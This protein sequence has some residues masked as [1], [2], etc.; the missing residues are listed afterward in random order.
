MST[1]TLIGKVSA[2]PKGVWSGENEY[3]ILD[4]VTHEG[5]GYISLQDVPAGTQITN[6]SYWLKFCEKGEKGDGGEIISASASIDS[7]YGTPTVSVFLGG[8]AHER[9]IGFEFSHLRGNGIVSV[10]KTST[11][12]SVDTYTITYNNG[13]TSTFTVTNGSVTSV[14][15]ETG[16]V[17]GVAETDGHYPELTS[18]SAEQLL[19]TQCLNDKVP[20]LYR[21]SGG[22]VNTGDRKS[23]SIVGGSIIWNQLVD[24]DTASVT[25]ADGHKYY[26]AINSVTTII[27]GD[28]SS[29]SVS[30]GDTVTD[31]TVMFGAAIADHAY[32]LEQSHTGDG[33][34]WLF[35]FFEYADMSY[36]AG[37]ILSVK[38]L[39]HETTGFNQWDEQWEE[40]IWNDSD[41]TKATGARKFRSKNGI[42]VIPGATYYYKASPNW[43]GTSIKTLFYGKD[44]HYLGQSAVKTV[45]AGTTFVIPD[46]AYYMAF[47][48]SSVVVATGGIVTY[49]N[50]ICINLSGYR[51]GEYEPYARHL[52]ALDTGIELH[53]IPKLDADSKLYYDGDVY[54]GD[55]KVKRRY[56]IVDLGTLEWTRATAGGTHFYSTSVRTV[57]KRPKTDEITIVCTKY[58]PM[59]NSTWRDTDKVI[60]L[61]PN[62]I[63]GNIIIKDT[64]LNSLTA[65]QFASA[66]SGVYFVYELAQS[67]TE[68]VY[69][70]ADTQTV[71]EF[72]TERYIDIR[73]VPVPVGHDTDYHV[74][75]RDKL[76]RLPDMPETEGF[77]LVQYSS[78]K[79]SFIPISGNLDTDGS[80]DLVCT[81]TDGV[82]A[83]SWV[84]RT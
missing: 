23:E 71:D 48:S 11:S 47:C 41:G 13:D 83:F 69:P 56:G 42:P 59:A 54:S 27:A 80:Y 39:Y 53:G 75:L 3:E 49:N 16:D 10:E 77:C 33:A 1:P 44:Q 78:R 65:E 58:K 32:S 17:T 70:F 68:S 7:T 76:Q 63:E 55:G 29:A 45:N 79:S 14:N 46:N 66:M 81:V 64:A 73:S 37:T 43:T 52:Y 67:V 82:P 28:G 30:A 26:A 19:S 34:E 31:L 8:T 22:S 40:G 12:G 5:N 24:D 25:L 50:D 74:N 36:N 21:T 20:Y 84:A 35:P 4:I 2:T 60:T 15:G 72:G 57:I 18:G 9:R 62:H 61:W 51:N 38:A 6:T